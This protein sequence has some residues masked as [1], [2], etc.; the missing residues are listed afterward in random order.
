MGRAR[1]PVPRVSSW[2]TPRTVLLLTYSADSWSNDKHPSFI[3]VRSWGLGLEAGC[4]Y[5]GFSWFLS[6]SPGKCWDST[7]NYFMEGMWKEAVMARFKALSRHLPGGTRKT[8]KSLGQDSWSLGRWSSFQVTCIYVRLETHFTCRDVC[9]V[10][11][12]ECIN[13]GWI[14]T[15]SN[16]TGYCIPL[17]TCAET[18]ILKDTSMWEWA[19]DIHIH[20]TKWI[21]IDHSYIYV[22]WCHTTQLLLEVKL[23][24]CVC[25][26]SNICNKAGDK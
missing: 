6:A 13:C 26:W 8:R 2:W 10:V 3:F 14:F 20:S 19:V 24:V 1:T 5:W 15:I 9:C 23:N 16:P 7:L 18:D 21:L 4:P 25:H 11:C 22:N 12:Y 17:M